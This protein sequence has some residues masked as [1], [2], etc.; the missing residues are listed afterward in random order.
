MHLCED[1]DCLCLFGFWSWVVDK[2][3]PFDGVF[4]K[5]EGSYLRALWEFSKGDAY[6]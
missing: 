2:I 3:M 6:D 1:M 5:Y 4:F